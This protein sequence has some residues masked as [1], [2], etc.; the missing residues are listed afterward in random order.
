MWNRPWRFAEGTAIALGLIIVGLLLQFTI[1]AIDWLLIAFPLNAFL[2]VIYLLVLG[3]L[4]TVRKRFYVVEWSMTM[5]CAVPALVAGV[6]VTL[7]MGLFGWDSMLRSWPFVLIYI[8]LMSILGLTTIHRLCHFSQG[9]WLRNICFICNHTGLFIAMVCGTLGYA[10]MQRLEMTVKVGSPEWRAVDKIHTSGTEVP[11]PEPGAQNPAL[12]KELPLAIELHSFTIDEYPPKYVIIDNET[13]Q[14]LQDS[15]WTIQADTVLEYAAIVYGAKDR[16]GNDVTRYTEWPS[17]GATTASHIIAH[18]ESSQPHDLTTVSG[19]VSCGSFMFPY[20]AL[21][22]D[23]Q[24]SAVMPEREPRRYAS[25]VTVYTEAGEKVDATIEVNH[26][27][28]VE[29]WKV[30][31]LSY[32]EALGRWSDTSVFELV[33]DPWLPYVYA[34]IF[35]MLAGAVL[36][37]LT[38]GKNRK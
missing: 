27:L 14:V 22:L 35:L 13:G 21:R 23:D 1:G 8:W 2:L 32:D 34:G 15:P 19:W 6:L 20:R 11:H 16:E 33:R 24:C 25:E 36:T 7:L 28:E 18:K 9:G 5:H 38:A 17:M 10:D 4:Y 3:V 37:F 12:V 29:G 26:P 31:Q 30:Y